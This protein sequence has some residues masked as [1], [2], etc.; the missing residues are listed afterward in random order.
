MAQTTTVAVSVAAKTETE[1]QE[2][3]KA[4][5]ILANILD[6]DSLVILANKAT[7]GGAGINQKIK[8]YQHFM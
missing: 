8:T 1:K 2:K 3:E 7:K 4:L 6:R 5:Q